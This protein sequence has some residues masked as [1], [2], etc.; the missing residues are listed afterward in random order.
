MGSNNTSS[1]SSNI[2]GAELECL[3]YGFHHRGEGVCL[4]VKMGPYRILLDC[5][6]EDISPL[7]NLEHPI[8]LVLCSHAHSDH[9]RGLLDLHQACPTVPF[10]PAKLQLGYYR[11][12]GK[13]WR[14]NNFVMLCLGDRPLNFITA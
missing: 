11:S 3:A 5:G 7:Q 1:S 9:A 10:T 2:G 6:I 4:L 12:I 8:D 13:K 14:F